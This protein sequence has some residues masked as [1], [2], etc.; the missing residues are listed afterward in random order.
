VQ[1]RKSGC[2]GLQFSDGST[3][4]NVKYIC[5]QN[6]QFTSHADSKGLPSQEKISRAD[7]THS[8]TWGHKSSKLSGPGKDHKRSAKVSETRTADC[9]LEF[10]KR[11]TLP[12][13]KHLSLQTDRFT[14]HAGFK[15]LPPK[16]KKPLRADQTDS[17]AEELKAS[18][19]SSSGKGLKPSAEMRKT[20]TGDP[21]LEFSKSSTLPNCKHLFLQ[22]C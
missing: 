16:E 21:G 2:D 3:S 10:S 8:R 19:F 4:Q 13:C 15:G 11:S 7:Q 6:N 14:S 22:K 18:Q 9:G 17:R 5:P 1:D 20:T 12:N